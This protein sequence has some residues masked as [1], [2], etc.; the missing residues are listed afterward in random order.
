MKSLR[1]LAVAVVLAF[2]AVPVLAEEGPNTLLGAGF[3]EVGKYQREV[4]FRKG[5][6]LHGEEAIAF[7]D[8]FL[9]IKERLPEK[10]YFE[11]ARFPEVSRY[12]VRFSDGHIYVAAGSG[13]TVEAALNDLVAKF[14]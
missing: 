10:S 11:I 14:K 6:G 8:A 5:S 4:E 1:I 12:H 9:E 7:R 3:E 13:S 2:F